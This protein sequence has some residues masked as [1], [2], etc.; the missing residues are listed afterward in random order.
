MLTGLSTQAAEPSATYTNPVWPMPTADPAIIRA[1]DGSFYVYATQGI[2]PD[3]VM[4]N[5]QVLCST[6]LVN[7]THLGDALPEKPVWAH[8]TRNFWAPHVS[9]VGDKYY[10]YFSA[11]PD[12]EVKT[13]TDLG[14]CLAVAVA[15]SPAGPF[16]DSGAPLVAGDGFDNIDPM[17]F[18][19]PASGKNYLYWGSGF[20]PLKVKELAAD[21]KSFAD[22]A[23]AVELVKAYG[24]GYGFLVEGSW[25]IYRDGYY[26]LFYSG[27]NC[28]GERA[29]YAVMVARSESPT[30]PFEVFKDDRE[31][32]SPILAEGSRW[33]ACGHNSIITDDAG[34][35][36]IVY[37]AIDRDKRYIKEGKRYE[38]KRVLMID[39]I[40]Y[41][42]GWPRVVGDYPSETEM[43]APVIKK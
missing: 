29:H 21:L 10:M 39:P 43:T 1:D 12:P 9:K 34:K 5:I 38:D 28:C 40:E 36:W 35:D 27:D 11:E 25:V 3:S 6:D 17:L 31:D 20:K 18:T 13:G 22:D 7:W 16:V 24:P 2:T 41:R 33:M 32:G 23:P 14:L 8:S 15:D 26:Y 42:D 19:D 37:H 4:C 30:G